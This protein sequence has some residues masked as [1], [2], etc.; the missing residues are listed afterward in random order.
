MA[1]YQSLFM[2]IAGFALVALASKQIGQFFH[3]I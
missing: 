3:Q 1:A 2:F